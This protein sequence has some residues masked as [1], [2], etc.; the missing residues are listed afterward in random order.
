MVS[1]KGKHVVITGGSQGIGL[2]LAEHFVKEGANVTIMARTEKTLKAAV[3][4]LQNMAKGSP[5]ITYKSVD[6]TS[7][8]SVEKAINDAE[9]TQPID[10]MI[11]AAGKAWPGYFLSQDLS[12]FRKHIDLNYFGALHT[13][14][15]VV[16]LMIGRRSGQIVFVSSAAIAVPFI[17]YSSYAP[18][19]AAL[20][21]LSDTLRNELIGFGVKVSVAY[22]PDTESPGYEE[23]MKMK[24]KECKVISEM[25]DKYKSE[26]VADDIIFGIKAGDYKLASPD[27]V[28]NRI[29]SSLSAG[30][31]P[32][33][34]YVLDI[35][36]SPIWNV[37]GEVFTLYMD[38]VAS[39]YAA[40]YKKSS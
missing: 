5:R 2:S 3:Q 11:C 29:M 25:G 7:F 27:F 20:S 26:P 39:G 6:V 38:Y 4:G 14:K 15:A 23:E 37:A 18:S 8:A 34:S 28:Q 13:A 21:T 24:P 31:T 33:A 1:F 10:Y 16:P 32:R 30:V 22:P 9:Q 19:K 35:V 12:V 17:G 40:N 36:L